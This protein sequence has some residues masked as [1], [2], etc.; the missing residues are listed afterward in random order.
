MIDKIS[1]SSS[2]KGKI[3]KK[4]NEMKVVKIYPSDTP[5]PKS[6]DGFGVFGFVK[7]H[8]FLWRLIARFTN[9]CFA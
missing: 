7:T 1:A 6:N 9:F 3:T 2:K 8:Q 5:K 4:L